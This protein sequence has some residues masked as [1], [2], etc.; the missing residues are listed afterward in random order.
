MLKQEHY[1][2]KQTE[3]I[4]YL[5]LEVSLIDEPEQPTHGLSTRYCDVSSF[6]GCLTTIILSMEATTGSGFF[7][8]MSPK[9]NLIRH[10]CDI[11]ATLYKTLLLKKVFYAVYQNVTIATVDMYGGV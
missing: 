8:A 1:E 6:I 5:C 4:S 11:S 7:Y 9:S 10:R 2:F 3:M